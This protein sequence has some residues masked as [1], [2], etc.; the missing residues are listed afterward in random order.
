LFRYIAFLLLHIKE[1]FWEENSS[2]PF[3]LEE[4]FW[5]QVLATSPFEVQGFWKSSFGEDSKWI[6]VKNDLLLGGRRNEIRESSL[7][8]GAVVRSIARC[9]GGTRGIERERRR[10]RNNKVLNWRMTLPLGGLPVATMWNHMKRR[11][12]QNVMQQG[13]GGA[14]VYLFVSLKY[15]HIHS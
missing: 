6:W 3:A 2:R 5:K 11:N 7:W 4:L 12:A 1:V 13:R 15:L 9:S 14:L 8:V 10:E